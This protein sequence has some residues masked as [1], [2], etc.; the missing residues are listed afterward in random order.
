M[1]E[2]RRVFSKRYSVTSQCIRPMGVRTEYHA[3]QSLALFQHDIFTACQNSIIVI[4]SL[5]KSPRY[6]TILFYILCKEKTN[7]VFNG[8]KCTTCEIASMANLNKSCWSFSLV[9]FYKKETEII[10]L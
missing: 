10:Y 8:L 1:Y 4:S 9:F 7:E 5:K 6:S 2:R 3:C